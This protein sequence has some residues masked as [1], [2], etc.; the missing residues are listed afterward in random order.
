MAKQ[1]RE[2][3]N[4]DGQKELLGFRVGEAEG[5]KFRIGILTELRK[6]GVEDMLIA[7]IDG[8]KGFP[9]AV[10]AAYPKTQVQLVI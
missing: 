2:G 7:A 10:A 5:A 3:I 1:D 6:R 9:E 4:S 8:L